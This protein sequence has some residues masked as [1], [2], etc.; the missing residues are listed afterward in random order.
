MVNFI[1]IWGDIISVLLKLSLKRKA[2]TYSNYFFI[3]TIFIPVLHDVI[4]FWMTR[5]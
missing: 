4:L 2:G 1:K 3:P 5:L